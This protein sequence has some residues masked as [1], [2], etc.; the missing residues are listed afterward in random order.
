M[1]DDDVS[2]NSGILLPLQRREIDADSDVIP[3]TPANSPYYY[4]HFSPLKKD[5]PASEYT[6]ATGQAQSIATQTDLS[7]EGQFFN[8]HSWLDHCPEVTTFYLTS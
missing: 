3:P 2:I 5:A 1:N 6:P 4:P 8:V 7:I